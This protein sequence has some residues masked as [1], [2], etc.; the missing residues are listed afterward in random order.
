ML[1][2]LIVAVSLISFYLGRMSVGG[3]EHIPLSQANSAS[4]I[5]TKMPESQVSTE[6][7]SSSTTQIS[8]QAVGGE[9]GN[10]VASRNGTKY[11]L[12]WCTGAKQI[13][14]GN[15]VWF[16]SKEDAEKAGYT[17]AAN[18]KGI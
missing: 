8:T 10:Y 17:P 3:S 2:V 15:K 1:A 11:H 12:P 6:V 16:A 7:T 14:E 5:E 4:V 13:K 18:C 9:Q